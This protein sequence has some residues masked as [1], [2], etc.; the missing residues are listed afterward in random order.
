MTGQNLTRAAYLFCEAT[1]SNEVEVAWD[2]ARCYELNIGM[3]R[4]IPKASTSEKG[5]GKNSEAC[6][7]IDRCYEFGIGTPGDF[8]KCSNKSS[9]S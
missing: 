2:A 7:A 8:S 4:N 1:D 3:P 9:Y 6:Y 5:D